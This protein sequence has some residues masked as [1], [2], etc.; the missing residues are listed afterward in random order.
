[1]QIYARNVALIPMYM[2]MSSLVVQSFSSA[3]FFSRPAGSAT[4]HL[5]VDLLY[6]SAVSNCPPAGSGEKS[7]SK[8][9]FTEFSHFVYYSCN[10]VNM[11][12]VDLER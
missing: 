1:M 5:R 6:N 7:N 8:C 4:H 9:C 10:F 2:Y 11:S 3:S 12:S